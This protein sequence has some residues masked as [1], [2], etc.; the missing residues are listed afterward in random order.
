MPARTRSRR[1]NCIVRWNYLYLSQQF[2]AIDDPA[3]R[4]EL[5][6]ALW[7]GSAA[8]SHPVNLLG[9]HDYFDERLKDSTIGIK[10]PKLI[11]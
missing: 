11:D 3:K 7:H 10:S 5:I 4:E 6:Q 9:E 8:S 1:M 2:A